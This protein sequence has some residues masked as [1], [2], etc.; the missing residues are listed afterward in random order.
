MRNDRVYCASELLVNQCL[1]VAERADYN[2]GVL[3]GKVRDLPPGEYSIELA[4]PE[5]T[6][7]LAAPPGPPAFFRSLLALFHPARRVGLREHRRRLSRVDVI[8]DQLSRH[9]SAPEP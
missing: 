1:A 3:E 9:R 8:R 2:W 4:I 5:L 7:K 6:D